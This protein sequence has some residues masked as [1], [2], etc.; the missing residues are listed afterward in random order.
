MQSKTQKIG[1]NVNKQ[2]GDSFGTR[3]VGIFLIEL[4]P[5]GIVDKIKKKNPLLS[6]DNIRILKKNLWPTSQPKF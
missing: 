1:T 2:N 5:I 4:E 3:V 6:R